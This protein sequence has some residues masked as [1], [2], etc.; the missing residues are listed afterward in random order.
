MKHS[1]PQIPR[2]VLQALHQRFGN[3]NTRVFFESDITLD[4]SFGSEFLVI[5]STSIITVTKERNAYVVSHAHNLSRIEDVSVEQLVGCSVLTVRIDGNAHRILAWSDAKEAI[6]DRAI[7][8]IRSI[9]FPSNHAYRGATDSH[10][11]AESDSNE[12]SGSR[13]KRKKAVLIRLMQFSRPYAKHSFALFGCMI[14][15]TAFGLATP[16]M[17]KLFI[18]YVF[19]KDPASGTYPLAHWLGVLV[20]LL[21]AAHAGQ[22]LFYGLQSR[23]AGWLG[24]KT[25]YDVR[26]TLYAKLQQLSLSFYDK[27]QTGSI[28]SR[29]NQDTGELQQFMVNFL[30]LTLESLLTLAGVGTFLFILSWQLTTFVLLPIIATVIF[31]HRVFPLMHQYMHRLFHNRARLSA[32]V[33]DSISGMRVIKSFGQEPLELEKF[34]IYNTS[35][36]D[37]GIDLTRKWSLYNPVLHTLIIVGSVLVWFVG[38]KMILSERMSI[39]SVV[40]YAGYLAMFY[41]PVFTLSRMIQMLFSSLSAA[42]R[43]FDILDTAPEIV[44]IP[45][46][47]KL[48]DIK[49]ALSFESV[50]FGY[51]S[52]KPVIH[53]MSFTIRENEIVGLVGKSG[54]GKSTLI[55]L[56]CRLYV[57]DKGR[58]LIDGHDMNEVR[59]QDVR[60]HIGVVLQETFLFNGTIYE[61]IAYAKP[62]ATTEEVIEASIAANAHEFILEKPDCY[63]TQVGERGNKLSG[64]EKQRISIAR[65]ILR[66]PR[67]LILDEATSSVDTETEAKIQQALDRLTHNRTTIAIAHRLS[68][69]R[70]CHRLFVI[71]E[72]RL[73]EIGTHEEL[74]ARKGIFSRLVSTQKSLNRI[75]ALHE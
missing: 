32:A 10:I 15:A 50:T 68:T 48:A 49:G 58:I 51:T 12:N 7:K 41:R 34:D 47:K 3:V 8:Q 63:D 25:V 13:L 69:L 6:F 53:D 36:R 71:D 4:G 56:M 74:L 24:H 61:N 75:F 39:G 54:A 26:K 17:S 44:D 57:P 52:T 29:V 19:K 33:N 2:A 27:H 62:E 14:T 59:F 70:N 73:V 64:G 38:G 9:L 16:Y 35:Y 11:P 40:A 22:Q 23:L 67:I 28:V 1:F 72:G 20:L 31:L 65:A 5:T 55:N 21:F 45:E 66:N 18:D 60:K 37:A 42:E 46:A 30:P 43:L